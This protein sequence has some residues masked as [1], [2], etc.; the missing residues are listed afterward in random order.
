MSILLR[1]AI[2]EE[3]PWIVAIYNSI[4]PGRMVTADTHPV[5][6]ED[7]INWFNEHH[8][9]RPLWMAEAN[10]ERVG[11]ASLQ[12]FYG[13]PAYSI[14]AEISIYLAEAC[15][16]KGLGK[17]VLQAGI[18]QSR[19]LGIQNLVGYIFEHNLP[20]LKLFEQAGFQRWARL[21]DVAEL[22]GIKRS[23]VILGKKISD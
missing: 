21:P 7:R 12:D 20:S 19:Q 22:D 16:G 13:R 9:Q 2:I 11:W 8:T 6:V 1:P 14:T 23:L 17:Q 18:E 4:I 5:T 3:L 15:R 10:G